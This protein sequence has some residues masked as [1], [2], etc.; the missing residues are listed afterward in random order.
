MTGIDLAADLRG[1]T[2]EIG[3]MRIIKEH[4]GLIEI[5]RARLPEIGVGFAQRG[6]AVISKIA[7]MELF[8]LVSGGGFWCAPYESGLVFRRMEDVVMAFKV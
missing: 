8:G 6:D 1:Y 2:T 4:G 7:E 5:A 3:A